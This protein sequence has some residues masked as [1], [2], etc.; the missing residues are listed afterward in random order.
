MPVDL[1]EKLFPEMVLLKEMAELEY[2][3]F[4]RTGSRP[5]SMPTNRH[6]ETDSYKSSSA[7]GSERL[8]HCWR[9]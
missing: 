4:V 6:M 5:R 1:P 9:K 8:N 2:S 3:R 7:P